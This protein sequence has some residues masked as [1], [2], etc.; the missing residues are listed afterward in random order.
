MHGFETQGDHLKAADTNSQIAK[1]NLQV[2]REYRFKYCN[3]D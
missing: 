3:K 2:A 1:P